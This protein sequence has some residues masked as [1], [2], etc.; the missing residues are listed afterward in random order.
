MFKQ[1][2]ISTVALFAL[3]TLSNATAQPWR[4]PRGPVTFEAMDLDGNGF[5]SSQEFSLHR[6]ARMAARAG[7]GRMLR[8]AGQAPSFEQWDSNGD[9]K[10][11][12]AELMAGQQ[13]RFAQRGSGLR[14]CR[15]DR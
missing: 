5:V 13:A 7:Q 10:L 4:E 2:L 15:R 12:P 8:N 14:P 9:G 3:A 1:I 6:E 11:S